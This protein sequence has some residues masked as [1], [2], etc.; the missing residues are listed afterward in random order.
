MLPDVLR[1]TETSGEATDYAIPKGKRRKWQWMRE[2]LEGCQWAR[3]E[4]VNGK[5]QLVGVY[6][7]PDLRAYELEDLEAEP[8]K[9]SNQ[10][11]GMVAIMLKAQEAALVRT[12]EHQHAAMD[13]LIKALEVVTDRLVHSEQHNQVLTE[14][15]SR[16]AAERGEGANDAKVAELV[17][18]ALVEGKKRAPAAAGK[19]T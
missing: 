9:L 18:G 15:L 1:V 6:D 19:G 2:I 8:T 13:A 14:A 11:A 7:H 10:V 17:M 5:D 4:G 16:M 12:G 3:V